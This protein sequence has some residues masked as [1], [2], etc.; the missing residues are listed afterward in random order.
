VLQYF[1][2]QNVNIEAFNEILPSLNDIF[3]GLVEG[4]KATTRAFQP[5]Q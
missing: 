1:L 5:V 2:Q 3:I 4:T